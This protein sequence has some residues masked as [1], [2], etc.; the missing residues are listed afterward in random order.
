MRAHLRTGLAPAAL[1]LLSGCGG[2]ASPSSPSMPS[3]YSLS[4][5]VFYDQNGNGV[6]DAGEPV[7][8]P[9]VTVS[10]AGQ[11]ATTGSGGAATLANLPAGAQQV[12]IDTTSLPPYYVAATA[13]SVQIPQVSQAVLP[14]TLPIGGNTPNTYMGFGD[15]ITQGQVG[16]G[17][18]T[19]LGYLGYLEPLL[20]EHFGQA[21][22]INEG[23]D[24]TRSNKGAARIQ[25]SLDRNHP[26][27]ILI[28]YGTND[29]NDPSCRSDFPCF[30]LDSLRTMV[31][32][33][34]A[35]HTLPFL[36]TIIP[37]N[38]GY[39]PFVPPE[40]EDWVHMM[41]VLIRD[42]AKQEGVALVDLEAAFLAQPDWGD[43]YYD[44]VH[45]N[46]AGYKLMSDTFYAAITSPRGATSSARGPGDEI[47]PPFGPDG[48]RIWPR[49]P[50]VIPPDPTDEGSKRP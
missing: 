43:L 46:D 33:A 20:A 11:K 10:A 22:T 47:L 17:S 36:A 21:I 7:R 49:F 37:P 15:S 40:R 26:A 3:S 5:V 8:L 34:K 19:G 6:L 14:V 41:D 39:D 18:S 38:T 12:S 24:A 44:H 16:D 29:W 1:I 2:G 31:E 32:A 42:L 25:D 30:T 4:V 23:A 9:G 35:V 13:L 45:P 28:H 27:F 48:R 50:S